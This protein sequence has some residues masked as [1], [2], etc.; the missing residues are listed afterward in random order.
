[1]DLVEKEKKIAQM[2]VLDTSK[3]AS[4]S[5]RMSMIFVVHSNDFSLCIGFIRLISRM[6]QQDNDLR[7]LPT[8]D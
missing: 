6:I 8:A 5:N 2:S 1:M 7:L 3:L 4:H